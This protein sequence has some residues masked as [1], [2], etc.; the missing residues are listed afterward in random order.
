MMPELKIEYMFFSKVAWRPLIRAID[1][2]N[3]NPGY[4]GNDG[5]AYS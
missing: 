3:K 4:G 5:D 2:A 1:F